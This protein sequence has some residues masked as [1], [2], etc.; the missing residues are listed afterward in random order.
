MQV[1]FLGCGAS[2]SF[3][4]S[5]PTAATLTMRHLLDERYYEE[6]PC[7]AIKSLRASPSLRKLPL[8][9]PI[10]NIA[11]LFDPQG[12]LLRSVSLCLTRRLW[13]GDRSDTGIL[14]RWLAA[15]RQLGAVLMTTNY[16]TVLERGI[17]KLT[18]ALDLRLLRDRRVIDYGVGAEL[19]FPRYEGVACGASPNPVRLLK[20][21]GSISWA[22]CAVC[23]KAALDA[24]YRD[25]AA[26]ALDGTT[27][28]DECSSPLSPILVGPAKKSYQHPIVQ[29]IFASARLALEQAEQIVFAGFSLGTGDERIRDLLLSAHQKARTP[30]VFVVDQCAAVKERY[31]QI[32]GHAVKDIPAMD[33]KQ[34]LRTLEACN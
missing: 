17:A 2:K 28:C 22:Y 11:D 25:R 13:A 20:L 31:R 26:D 4:P 34:Y 32:Y 6:P 27:T 30:Q 15:V 12:D 21:H 1:Y 23:N 18:K 19:L 9:V 14:K 7:Q 8:D 10:E 24:S 16:D 5:L 29:G 3:Y 33:W